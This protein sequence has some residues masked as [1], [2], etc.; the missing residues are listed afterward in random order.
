[1]LCFIQIIWQ[2]IRKLSLA[3]QY[4]LWQLH[5][6]PTLWLY[7]NIASVEIC[8]CMVQEVKPEKNLTAK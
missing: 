8:K 5:H 1:M 2:D 3:Y 7:N 4:I 6:F